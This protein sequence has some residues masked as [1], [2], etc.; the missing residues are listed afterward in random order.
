MA[1]L[2]KLRCRHHALGSSGA[3]RKYFLTSAQGLLRNA[4]LQFH[5]RGWI[6]IPGFPNKKKWNSTSWFCPPPALP[7]YRGR[8]D[9]RRSRKFGLVRLQVQEQVFTRTKRVLQG[10][11]KAEQKS[12]LPRMEIAW[13]VM[14]SWLH[15]TST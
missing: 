8:D 1:S 5:L 3:K 9:E 4:T 12:K 14:D 7:L 2:Q 13:I 15:K 11:G 10:I 6:T